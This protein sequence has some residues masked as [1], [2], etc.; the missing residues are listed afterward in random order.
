MVVVE[1]IRCVGGLFVLDCVAS[2]TLFVDMQA[3]GVDIL[4]TAPQKGWSASPCA[5]AVMMSDNGR[6]ML[7]R[8][9]S[10]SFANDLKKWT[11]IMEVYEQGKHAYHATMPTDSLR[12][13]RDAL[14][15]C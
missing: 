6:K 14:L 5:A 4:L 13:F 11:E 15:D 10:S 2:G 8:T 3:C 9:K 7:D 12:L 1:M